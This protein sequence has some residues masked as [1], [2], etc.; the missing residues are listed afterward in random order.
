MKDNS[1]G[2]PYFGNVCSMVF[3]QIQRLDVQR[4]PAT[5]QVLKS[6]VMHIPAPMMSPGAVSLVCTVPDT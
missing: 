4:T 3:L 5:F 1:S 6:R 2:K